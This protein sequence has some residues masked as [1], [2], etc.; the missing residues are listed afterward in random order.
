MGG[1]P[2][3]AQEPRHLGG[4]K[5]ENRDYIAGYAGHAANSD[6]PLLS[7]TYFI[8]RQGRIVGMLCSGPLYTAL[9]ADE[10]SAVHIDHDTHVA[11][12]T[13]HST[14]PHRTHT[15]QLACHHYA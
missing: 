2:A 5:A 10:D 12:L 13:P 14:Y 6:I 15:L 3:T 4:G 9:A 1:C 7:S 11:P 8:R